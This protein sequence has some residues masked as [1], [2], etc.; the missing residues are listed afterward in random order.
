MSARAVECSLAVCRARR[1]TGIRRPCTRRAVPYTVRYL[2]ANLPRLTSQ[3]PQRDVANGV[4]AGVRRVKCERADTKPRVSGCGGAGHQ[5]PR[6][7][8]KHYRNT[9]QLPMC[10]HTS[11]RGGV[12]HTGACVPLSS[13]RGERPRPPPSARVSCSIRRN[14]AISASHILHH[15]PPSPHPFRPG[16][17]TRSPISYPSSSPKHRPHPSVVVP[18]PA[19][20]T[21]ATRTAT[22]VPKHGEEGERVG[23]GECPIPP[24]RIADGG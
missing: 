9:L 17:P 14:P 24:S 13:T 18:R 10:A 1:E 12:H 11:R 3:H 23:G 22:V 15:T 16:I 4:C 7:E 2:A 6:V 21:P 5:P 20:R 19:A 8:A